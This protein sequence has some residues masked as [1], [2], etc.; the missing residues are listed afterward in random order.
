LAD[1]EYVTAMGNFYTNY[2]LRGPSQQAVAKA[3][4]GRSAIVTPAQDGCVVVFDEQSD[5]QNEAVITELASSLSRQFACPV[6]AVLNHDDDIFWYQLY[7]AGE[8]A[9]EYDSSPGYFDPSAEPSAPAG[10]DAQK[11][12]SAF[13]ADDVAEVESVLRKSSFHEGGYTFAVE[14]HTDLARA[15]GI[16]SFGVGAGFRYVAHGELPEGLTDD[17][18]TRTT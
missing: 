8:L 14:R 12:C 11:L 15:L 1:I 10:G 5:E 17:D 7:L 16:P 9:D 3:L 18:L 6:L 2:T 13:G 4:G